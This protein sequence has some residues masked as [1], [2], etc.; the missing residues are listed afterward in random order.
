[1]AADEEGG[2]AC[3]RE[4]TGV[5]RRPPW[6]FDADSGRR[7][8][9]QFFG[10]HDLSGFGLEELPLA[11]AAAGAVLGYGEEPQKQRLPHLTGI[12]VEAG[13]GA[14]ARTAAPRRHLELDSRS[15][16]DVRTT[17]LG[18]LDTTI[19]PVGGRLL[20]RWLHRPLRDRDVLGH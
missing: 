4:R 16:G 12:A 6:L 7:Q 11:T 10:L 3:R 5:R 8:L 18:V 9:L 14:I 17:L 13:D 15:D 2:P 20:R 1:L 19:T